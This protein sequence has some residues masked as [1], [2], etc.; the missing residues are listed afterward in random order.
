MLSRAA[1]RPANIRG[2]AEAFVDPDPA[3]IPAADPK[4]T[5][6]RTGADGEKMKV[7]WADV[8]NTET[9]GR[10]PLL[11]G[12][13][14][15]QQQNIDIWKSKPTARFTVI[16]FTAIADGV[17]RYVLGAYDVPDEDF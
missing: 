5:V 2:L 3:D 15:V 9:P 1:R 4:T 17:E 13:V 11:G 12:T 8:N 6:C 10:F 14:R 7:S 16:P